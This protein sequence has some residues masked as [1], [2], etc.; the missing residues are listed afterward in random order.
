MWVENVFMAS[1]K[2]SVI[3]RACRFVIFR[4]EM[5]R[6][7][8]TPKE[9]IKHL[10]EP[11]GLDDGKLPRTDMREVNFNPQEGPA[12]VANGL[13]ELQHFRRSG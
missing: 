11:F 12:K 7:G 1:I 10:G 9:V 2:V 4:R 6:R 3:A 8:G 5:E 13:A